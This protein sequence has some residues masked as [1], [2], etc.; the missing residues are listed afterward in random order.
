[1]NWD[2]VRVP[3]DLVGFARRGLPCAGL[4]CSALFT[5]NPRRHARLS[6]REHSFRSLGKTPVARAHCC[7]ACDHHFQVGNPLASGMSDAKSCFHA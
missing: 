5:V 2:D 3:E 6:L 1:V 4:L 7:D